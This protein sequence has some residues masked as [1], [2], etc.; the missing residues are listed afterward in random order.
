MFYILIVTDMLGKGENM[1][2]SEFR[3][4]TKRFSGGVLQSMVG[5]VFPRITWIRE[6]DHMPR[7]D[8]QLLDV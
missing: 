8:M 1:A 3:S 2:T 4:L 5:T 7:R 6:A